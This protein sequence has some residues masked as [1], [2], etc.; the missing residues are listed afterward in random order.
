M[1][2]GLIAVSAF[3]GSDAPGVMGDV[4][5]G[6]GVACLCKHHRSASTHVTRAKPLLVIATLLLAAQ[7]EQSTA[8]VHT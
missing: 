6:V 8:G 1:M 2:S 3:R 5:R 7:I 4:G